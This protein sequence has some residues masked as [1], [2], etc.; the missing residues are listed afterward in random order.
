MT[1]TSK[2]LWKAR[3]RNCFGLPW[4]FTTYELRED[5]VEDSIS[6]DEL[7]QNSDNN[8]GDNVVIPKVVG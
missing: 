6:K 7:L 3:K 2:V 1:D 5:V 8:D 4:T